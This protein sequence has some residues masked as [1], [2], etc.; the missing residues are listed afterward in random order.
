MRTAIPIEY[1]NVIA[2]T[3]PY[4]AIYTKR[5]NNGKLIFIIHTPW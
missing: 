4:M 1:G 3:H 5:V 2:M